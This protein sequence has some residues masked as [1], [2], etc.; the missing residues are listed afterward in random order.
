M[1]AITFS[2][3]DESREFVQLLQVEESV[4]SGVGS[5]IRGTLAG[6]PLIVWHI[7]VGRE[8]AR[9]EAAQLLAVVKPE[10]VICAGYGG[11]LSPDLRLGEIVVDHRGATLEGTYEGRAGKI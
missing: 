3:P 1:L 5:S 11:A 9:L 8:R 2:L 7:G 6:V 4:G 10:T